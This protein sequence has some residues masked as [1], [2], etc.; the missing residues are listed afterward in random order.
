MSG[1]GKMRD[2]DVYNEGMSAVID[3]VSQSIW[4]QKIVTVTNYFSGEI[5]KNKLS[6]SEVFSIPQVTC[7]SVII[8]I[9]GNGED[10]LEKYIYWNPRIKDSFEG[11]YMLEDLDE[12]E[13]TNRVVNLATIEHYMDNERFT[14]TFTPIES[15]MKFNVTTNVSELP[16]EIAYENTDTV[17]PTVEDNVQYIPNLTDFDGNTVITNT[18][19]KILTSTMWKTTTYPFCSY[20][21]SRGDHEHKPSTPQYKEL[22]Q[23]TSGK[24]VIGWRK[25]N[26]RVQFAHHYYIDA[27]NKGSIYCREY[28]D[29]ESTF[30]GS[31]VT[32]EDIT[33]LLDAP[34]WEFMIGSVYNTAHPEI[35]A[36][37]KNK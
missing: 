18:G 5:E 2:V 20:I 25:Q 35:D 10:E 33:R 21:T 31:E 7:G 24:L 36:N 12:E 8:K 34:N 14:V 13:P 6:P 30:F 27:Y 17:F 22:L 19:Q 1:D 16:R 4:T 9:R 28:T 37:N 11:Y 23:A 3:R 26:K 29:E 15:L 32:T